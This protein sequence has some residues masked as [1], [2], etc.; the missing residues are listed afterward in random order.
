MLKKAMSKIEIEE[1]LNGK[2]DFVQIDYLTRFLKEN[3]PIDIKRFVYYK[4]AVIYE[5]KC[6]FSEAAKMYENMAIISIAFSEKIKN[7]VKETEL[8]I[9]AGLFDRADEAMKKAMSDAN[10]NQRAE[11]YFSI[12]TFY[13]NQAEIYERELR[14]NNAAKIYEKLLEMNLQESERQEIKKNLLFLYEKLGKFRESDK[15][16]RLG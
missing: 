8:F 10:A 9:K 15:L 2:G 3:P 4:L 1:T 7:Y 6:L 13:K 16:K 5:K 14:K 12:K 11:I